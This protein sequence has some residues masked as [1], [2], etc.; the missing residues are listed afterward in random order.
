M[1]DGTITYLAN[2]FEYDED[3][4]FNQTKKNQDIQTY[5]L[6]SREDLAEYKGFLYSSYI[7]YN[8]MYIPIMV[9]KGFTSWEEVKMISDYAD[10]YM[11]PLL[12]K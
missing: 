6:A 5:G 1:S 11:N 12:N 10:K 9:G 3:L 2:L 8:L 7:D 4:K